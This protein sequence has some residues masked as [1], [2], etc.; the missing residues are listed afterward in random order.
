M[1]A[2]TKKLS[3]VFFFH[4][5]LSFRHLHPVSF[6]HEEGVC[7]QCFIKLTMPAGAL[8]WGED[9]LKNLSRYLYVLSKSNAKSSM[10]KVDRRDGKRF[11]KKST[12]SRSL[13]AQY[14]QISP[15]L[16]LWWPGHARVTHGISSRMAQFAHFFCM[17]S[18]LV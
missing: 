13:A 16:S 1:R 8:D 10:A 15:T 17:Y 4:D 2:V 6:P 18:S 7:E 11:R 9:G 5:R 12:S 14:A 3:L